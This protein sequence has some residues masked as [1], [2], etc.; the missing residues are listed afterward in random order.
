[1]LDA[2]KVLEE[3]KAMQVLM[4]SLEEAQGSDRD[5]VV[6]AI[7]EQ[8]K[9]L[10]A[11]C[12]ELEAEAKAQDVQKPEDEPEIFVEILLTPEQMQRVKTA[13]GV[14]IPSIKLKDPTGALSKNMQHIEPEFVEEKAMEKAEQFNEMMADLAELQEE[15]AET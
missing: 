10:Q 8:A 13:T 4:D 12:D 5:A 11:A 3:R 9:R 7:Q 1:M 15:D 14:E 2:S 6:E